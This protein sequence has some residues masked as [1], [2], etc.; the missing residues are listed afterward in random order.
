MNINSTSAIYRSVLGQSHFDF[1][2]QAGHKKTFYQ[3]ES[4]VNPG[5]IFQYP[6]RRLRYYANVES[7]IQVIRVH[8]SVWLKTLEGSAQHIT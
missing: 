1:P 8:S 5:L 6:N 3:H 7:L 2:V 4:R